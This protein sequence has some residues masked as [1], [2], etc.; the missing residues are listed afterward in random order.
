MLV[1]IIAVHSL[2]LL[3][4]AI[5]GLTSLILKLG[6]GGGGKA[7]TMTTDTLEFDP[8]SMVKTVILCSNFVVKSK[9]NHFDHGKFVILRSW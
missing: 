3:A 1:I 4:M 5:K 6:G 2:N 7:M 8:W 9:V